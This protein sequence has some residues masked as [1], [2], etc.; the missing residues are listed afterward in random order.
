[1]LQGSLPRAPTL[2][3]LFRRPQTIT[4]GALIA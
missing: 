3:L 1:M 4:E 2:A